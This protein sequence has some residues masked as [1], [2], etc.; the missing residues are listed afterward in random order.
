[1]ALI[2]KDR[3]FLIEVNAGGARDEIS[4]HREINLLP[5]EI[6]EIRVSRDIEGS[7]WKL[8]GYLEPGM[9]NAKASEMW[10]QASII[11]IFL[12]LAGFISCWKIWQLANA[13]KHAFAQLE[14][15]NGNLATMADEQ[16]SLRVS[17][18]AGEETKAQFLASMSHEI[19]TPLN[20]VIGLTELVLKTD[21]D[22]FQKNYL[23]KVSFAGKNLL[24]L[25]NDILD[26]SKIEAGKLQIENTVFELDPVLENVAVVVNAKDEENR[27]EMIISVDRTLPDQLIG[28]PLRL[29]QVM[30]NLA[31]NAA[32]FTSDGEIVIDVARE[33][34][35]SG[36]W[37]SI[38]VR[39][40]GS[41]MPPE[42]TAKLFKPFV[43]ADQSVTRTHGG[44]GLGLSISLQ[45]VEAMGGSIGVESAVGQGSRFFFK[46]PLN[47][48]E[49]STSRP[50]FEGIDPRITKILV[51]DD[52]DI[53]RETVVLALEKLNF[54]IESASTGEDA[55]KKITNAAK[56]APFNAI[57]MD[58]MMTS[59]NCLD[60][61]KQMQSKEIDIQTPVIVMVSTAD[62]DA[63][64]DDL[65]SLN[66][67]HVLQKPINTSF[68][69]DTLMAI[70]ETDHPKRQVRSTR[71][72]DQETSI[73]LAGI[74]ILLA[75]DNELNQMVA[76]GVLQGAGAIVD[77]AE[78]G[79]EALQQLRTHDASYYGVVLM[80]T[81][82]LLSCDISFW[83]SVLPANG[84]GIME[85][86]LKHGDREA[87]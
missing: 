8:V 26:F 37:L 71:L 12:L 81:V 51:V 54:K 5:S 82:G 61:L 33:T 87:R 60:V 32:K 41:G 16:R 80:D 63:I 86:K 78:N 68:L 27:N 10:T 52:N 39:D 65:A 75:E 15:S 19:R 64:P 62:M 23:S 50:V 55:I 43:Q 22:D 40:N 67:S 24:A 46:S 9:I 79:A 49:G 2:N 69:I 3:D 13:Q 14:L 66:I 85:A 38:S 17:A 34:D 59:I 70:F 20:A 74:R 58:W 31:G 47:I 28:D 44:T 25:I 35:A 45:L 7:K 42:Q 53:I 21:L 57:L 1:M 48:P 73:A 76:I 18:K 11:F 84:S 4:A 56:D 72:G 6:A 83:F 36:D 29:G 30:I 77:V